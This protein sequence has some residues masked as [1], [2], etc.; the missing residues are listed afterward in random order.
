MNATRSASR[1]GKVLQ[2][3]SRSRMLR[4]RSDRSIGGAWRDMPAEVPQIVPLRYRKPLTAGWGG[5]AR[6][7]WRIRSASRATCRTARAIPA[8]ACALVPAASGALMS[9]GELRRVGGGWSVTA[10]FRRWRLP[11][12]AVAASAL[13]RTA[14]QV[15]SGVAASS[16]GSAS[17]KYHRSFDRR[18]LSVHGVRPVRA[19]T[20]SSKCHPL[21]D[22]SNAEIIAAVVYYLDTFFGVRARWATPSREWPGLRRSRRRCEK[23]RGRSD[24]A[25]ALGN[26]PVLARP[27]DGKNTW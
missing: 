22:R 21:D 17:Q 26:A 15:V 8:L 1:F 5:M 18:S 27:E 6:R 14:R 4:W 24:R 25:S 10:C 2:R 19:A 20:A 13:A 16:G 11:T 3:D 7:V 12:R 9:T 23:L